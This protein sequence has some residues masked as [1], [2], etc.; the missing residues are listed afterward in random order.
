MTACRFSR[1]SV[2]PFRY[3]WSWIHDERSGRDV[4]PP[5][6]DVIMREVKLHPDTGLDP[7]D[8]DI[9]N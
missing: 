7:S 8:G 5:P 1:H 9:S 3:F 2:V 4:C 6:V